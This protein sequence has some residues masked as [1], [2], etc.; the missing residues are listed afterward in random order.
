MTYRTVVQIVTPYIG[1]L[2]DFWVGTA[3]KRDMWTWVK[4]NAGRGQD[5]R[6]DICQD[7]WFETQIHK[8]LDWEFVVLQRVLTISVLLSMAHK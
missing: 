2:L 1:S 4:M 6:Y 7:K 3:A 5:R 8:E